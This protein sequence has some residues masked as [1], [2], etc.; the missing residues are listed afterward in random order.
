MVEALN[1]IEALRDLRGMSREEALAWLAAN[2][3]EH[4]KSVEWL[5]YYLW[6]HE[7]IAREA[8]HVRFL[9]HV[10]EGNEAGIGRLEA[11]VVKLNEQ[12]AEQTRELK[13]IAA[14]LQ[15]TRQIG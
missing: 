6:K 14:P 1:R 12:I 8:D 10:M 5:R 11:Q 7:R 3:A 4:P 9:T 15:Q 13:E 2:E